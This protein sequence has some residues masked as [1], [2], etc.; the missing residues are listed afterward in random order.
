[1]ALTIILLVVLTAAAGG[2]LLAPRIA[3]SRTT[4]D[5]APDTPR[6]FGRNMAW[7]AIRTRDTARVLGVLGLGATERS[8]WRCGIGAVYDAA[9]SDGQIYVSPP[10]NG[11]T[12]VVGLALPQPL[13][14]A[15][16]DRSTPFL[17]ELGK[18]FIEVQYYLTCPAIDYYAWARIVDGKF[19]RAFA[20]SDE[21]VLW[22]KG[23]PGKDEKAL[24][25][26][27]F[28]LRGVS[29]RQGDAGGA[30]L[31]HPTEDHVIRLAARWSLDPTK[32]DSAAVAPALGVIGLA[33]PAW[34]PQTLR[35][36]A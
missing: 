23:R 3:A 20:V 12:F 34:R 22:N 21:A 16:A 32:L 8:N 18:Q 13:G 25:L 2:F 15:F 11:W 30:L 27:S 35:K 19:A 33:P 28:E 17:L 9:E 29:G 14:R 26:Q 31:L 5:Y 4:Y 6:A 10:V 24:G 1:M 36:S 7:L